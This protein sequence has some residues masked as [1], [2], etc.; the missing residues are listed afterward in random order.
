[1]LE[2][3]TGQGFGE[4]VRGV[5]HRAHASEGNSAIFN[6]LMDVME[7][8]VDMF[9]VGVTNMVLC[10]VP[11]SIV[12]TQKRCGGGWGK[13]EASE[14]FMKEGELVGGIVESNISIY[15]V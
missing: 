2:V 14:E 1:M 6:Q 10:Q 12:V 7:F 9:Y 5:V 11:S 4:D 15:S 13:A 8:D 3:P